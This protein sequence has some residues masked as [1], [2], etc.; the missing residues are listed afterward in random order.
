MGHVQ[1]NVTLDGV[2]PVEVWKLRAALRM[3]HLA[4]QF[5]PGHWAHDLAESVGLDL[6]DPEDLRGRS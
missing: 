4:S 3:A 5:P 6:D 1:R 2:V